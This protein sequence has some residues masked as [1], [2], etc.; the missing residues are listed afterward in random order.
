MSQAATVLQPAARVTVREAR[1]EDLPFVAALLENLGYRVPPD[2]AG[3]ILAESRRG[4]N[5]RYLLAESDSSSAV[6]LIGLARVPA[7]RLGGWE[8]HITE[9]VVCPT[10]RGAGVGA[11]LLSHAAQWARDNG[12]V[13]IEVNTSRSRD[14]F[15]RRFY[16]KN[17][18][19]AA[20]S[21]IFRCVP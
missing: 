21:S 8:V 4:S 14:S 2:A 9:L 15:R 11:L 13:R 10:H 7:L 16:E 1:P 19:Q 17:G 12:A 18:F 3:S 5:S 20:A 6:G